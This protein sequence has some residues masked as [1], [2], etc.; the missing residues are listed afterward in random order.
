MRYEDSRGWLYEVRPGL[1]ETM[2]KIFYRK[3]RENKDLS[4]GW[5][6]WPSSKWWGTREEAERE[7]AI[8]A[9]NRSWWKASDSPSAK[10]V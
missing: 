7:L 5:H 2:F 6:A 8:V 10:A 3:P 9:D 4:I 1:G